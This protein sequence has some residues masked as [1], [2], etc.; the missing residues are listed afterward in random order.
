MLEQPLQAVTQAE[1][2]LATLMAQQQYALNERGERVIPATRRPDG[3]WRKER[4]VKEG[5]IP[6][7]E[8]PKYAPEAAMVRA[9]RPPWH[10]AK[11]TES[12]RLN[13]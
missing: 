5:Y 10:V 8:Q 1:F 2:S 11:A 9:L 7:E 13:C 6:Q 12:L 4:R 3:T